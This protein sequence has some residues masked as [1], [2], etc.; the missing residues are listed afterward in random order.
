MFIFSENYSVAANSLKTRIIQYTRHVIIRRFFRGG[1]INCNI[2]PCTFVIIYNNIYNGEVHLV[3]SILFCTPL[4]LRLC[5]RSSTQT[6]AALEFWGYIIDTYIISCTHTSYYIIYKIVRA[7]VFDPHAMI[8]T[9]CSD[10]SVIIIYI[11]TRGGHYNYIVSLFS[12][13]LN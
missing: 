6:R 12:N 7:A 4:V 8:S 13:Q 11:G 1:T 10:R 9:T 5:T 3:Q 2:I